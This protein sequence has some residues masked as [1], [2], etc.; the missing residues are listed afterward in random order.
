MVERAAVVAA[1]EEAEPQFD[2]ADPESVNKAKKKAGRNRRA[3]LE[4]V[5][6]IMRDREGRRWAHEFLQVGHVFASSFVQGDPHATS[7]R[8]GERNMAQRLLADIVA[9]APEQWLV[10]MSEAK[11]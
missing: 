11:S 9:A 7:F 8:E 4:F 10:M 2:A 1:E 6:T 5:A 3:R